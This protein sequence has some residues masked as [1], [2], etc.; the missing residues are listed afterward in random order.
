VVS[1]QS[2]IIRRDTM[3]GADDQDLP[4]ITIDKDFEEY[5]SNLEH[6]KIAS[7]ILETYMLVFNL[8]GDLL[9]I[10]NDEE[11]HAGGMLSG[12]RPEDMTK[13]FPQKVVIEGESDFSYNKAITD[14]P[15]LR[16]KLTESEIIPNNDIFVRNNFRYNGEDFKHFKNT[17]IKDFPTL[18]ESSASIEDTPGMDTFIDTLNISLKN[19]DLISL[20]PESYFQTYNWR[21]DDIISEI[22]AL[23]REKDNMDERDLKI[24][25]K[26]L[27]Q[28]LYPEAITPVLNE[29][30]LDKPLTGLT[31]PARTTNAA[32]GF[33]IMPI[34]FVGFV[35]AMPMFQNKSC[36]MDVRVL[37]SYLNL[38][39]DDYTQYVIRL[40]S[41]EHAPVVKQ[42]IEEYVAMRGLEYEVIDYN[43]SG[44]LY[45]PSAEAFNIVFTVLII[46]FLIISIIFTANLV[47]LSII[48]RRK[49]IGM[50]IT[51]G[52]G[53][54]ENILL[55]LGEIAFILTLAWVIGALLGGGFIALCSRIGIP[56]MFFFVDDML[57]LHFDIKHL[58]LAY[59]LLLPPAML[60][61]LIPCLSIYKLDPVAI[62]QEAN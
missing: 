16:Q 2:S 17:V 24:L 39:P 31:F 44:K 19:P 48:K 4:L 55:F 34:K 59:L 49:E 40:E 18:F 51:I 14:I 7:P 30:A 42:K 62:L 58:L 61:A 60:A 53:K 8:E 13:L 41:K 38:S 46:L 22:E 54:T 20:I 9:E 28:T 26:K 57:F 52:L 29:I 27:F 32:D 56:K 11:E 10:S 37:Q 6:V 43:Y 23:R 33:I 3:L 45:M 12:M 25:N 47:I 36:I 50:N 35:T 21:L 5:V 15:V 1:P